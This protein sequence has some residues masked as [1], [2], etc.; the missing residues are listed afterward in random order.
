MHIHMYLYKEFKWSYPII[1]NNILFGYYMILAN[2]S[3]RNG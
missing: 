2:P 3:T 1:R